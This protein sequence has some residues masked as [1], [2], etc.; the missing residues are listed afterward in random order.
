MKYRKKP[1]SIEAIQY[2]GDNAAEILGFTE[3]TAM[4]NT[5]RTGNSYLTIPTLEGKH[6][7]HIGDF[8]IKGVKG[9]FYPCKPDIFHM[10][11][12][13]EDSK[14]SPVKEDRVNL[15]EIK[16]QTDTDEA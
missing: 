4:I 13:K 16:T 9:E 5:N 15:K 10:S 3:N 11:Y 1:V 2:T 8:V 14:P 6:F 12:E 7:A